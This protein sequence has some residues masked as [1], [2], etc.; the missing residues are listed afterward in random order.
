MN[1]INYS[2]FESF[3]GNRALI[4]KWSSAPPNAVVYLCVEFCYVQSSTPSWVTTP[5]WAT[6]L[7]WAWDDPVV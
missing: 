4:S 3:V 1:T 2:F 5:S 6:Y 7:I